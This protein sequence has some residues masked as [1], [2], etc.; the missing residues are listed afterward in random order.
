MEE[1]SNKAFRSFGKHKI[2]VEINE[3]PGLARH[4][5]YSGSSSGKG[6]GS[7]DVVE[8]FLCL[9]QGGFCLFFVGRMLHTGGSGS[10]VDCLPK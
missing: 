10:T 5:A 9:I 2:T 4:Q 3:K 8:L 1:S 7:R 6:V